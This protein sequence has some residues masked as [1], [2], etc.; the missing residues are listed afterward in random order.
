MTETLF[1]RLG[2]ELRL[3]E[4]ID[5]FIDR[6]FADR[7]IGFFFR[8]ADKKRIKEMEYQLTAEFLGAPVKYQGK[9]LALAHAKHPIMGG[10]F[11]RRLK[12]LKETLDEFQAPQEIQEAWLR[13]NESLR[14]SIT[15]DSG[16]DCDPAQARKKAETFHKG[17]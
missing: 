1:A 2:G 9:P 16:S 7:M 10:Q 8:N 3:R 6:V 17:V 12:I 14:S 5:A 15:A 4:I 13:H 11:A